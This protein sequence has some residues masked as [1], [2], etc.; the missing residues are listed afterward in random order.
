MSAVSAKE[1]WSLWEKGEV[2]VEHSMGQALQILVDQH[3]TINKH[4]IALT[5]QGEQQARFNKDIRQLQ[6]QVKALDKA[7]Q[8]A[9]EEK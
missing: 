3:K 4:G 2:Q 7:L 1:L 6:R 5:W 8:K 9:L